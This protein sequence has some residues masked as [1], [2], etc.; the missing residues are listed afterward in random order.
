MKIGKLFWA[1]E[2]SLLPHRCFERE[3]LFLSKARDK[4]RGMNRERSGDVARVAGWMGLA[5]MRFCPV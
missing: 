1:R 3:C 5:E 2:F 4:C